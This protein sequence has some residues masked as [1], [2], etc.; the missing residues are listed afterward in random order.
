MKASPRAVSGAQMDLVEFG[1]IP[2]LKYLWPDSETLNAELRRV[3]MAKMASSPGVGTTVSSRS[4]GSAQRRISFGTPLRS[5]NFVTPACAASE[6]R[7]P[8]ST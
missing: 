1:A 6:G 8:S 7:P 5:S 2:V 4:K 3:I